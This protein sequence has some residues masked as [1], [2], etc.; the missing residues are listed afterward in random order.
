MIILSVLVCTIPERVDMFTKLYNELHR[1][2]EYM[3]TFHTTLGHIEIL[4]NSDKRFLEGGPSIGRKRGELVK[5]AEGKYLC[6]LDDDESISGNYLETLVR[7]CIQD[8]D[9]CTFRNI[10]KLKD[11]WM[12]VDMSLKYPIN[13]QAT[14]DFMIRRRPW[15]ISPVRSIFAKL[16]SFTDSNYGED[17]AWFE[18]VLS[19]CLTEAKSESIIHQYNHG[20]HSESDKIM[21]H[22]QP[23]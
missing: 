20:K 9:V 17:W 23:K 12:I 13:D 7:L 2:L 6:F 19:H 3:Q 14:P 16:H 22:A 4:V 21:Q 18:Q 15:H 11:Y 5:R 1:Q 10:S 8:R